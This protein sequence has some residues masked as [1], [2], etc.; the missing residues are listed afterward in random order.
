[1]NTNLSNQSRYSNNDLRQSSDDTSHSSSAQ[2]ITR[3]ED[4]VINDGK[5]SSSGVR[6]YRNMIIFHE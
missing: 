2:L 1:M 6:L 5:P 4:D 3:I